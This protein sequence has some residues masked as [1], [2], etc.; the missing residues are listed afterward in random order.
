MLPQVAGI[1]HRNFLESMCSATKPHEWDDVITHLICIKE[2]Q[3]FGTHK[4]VIL[5]KSCVFYCFARST[6][7]VTKKKG[8]LQHPGNFL[9]EREELARLKG[10]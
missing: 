9:T 1:G 5:V 4:Y 3:L 6:S 7:T 10:N 2:T 8:T